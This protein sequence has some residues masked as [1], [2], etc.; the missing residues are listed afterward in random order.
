MVVGSLFFFLI[1]G[2]E[3]SPEIPTLPAPEDFYLHARTFSAG[4][5]KLQGKLGK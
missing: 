2:V 3:Y 4:Y 5:I 1:G